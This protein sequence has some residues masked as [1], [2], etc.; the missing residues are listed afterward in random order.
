MDLVKTHI[1][2]AENLIMSK[3]KMGKQ[4]EKIYPFSNENIAA[5]LPHFNLQGKDC[6]T[7]LGSGDQALDFAY[8]GAKTIDTFDINP[9][10][11]YYFYLK[12]AALMSN[13]SYQEYINFFCFKEYLQYLDKNW[14]AFNE[15][16]FNKLVPYLKDDNYIFW[17]TLF[18]TFDFNPV[19][20]RESNGLFT[21][22]EFSHQV[23]SQSIAYLNEKNYYKL[24]EKASSININ[25][26]NSN[27]K[28]LEPKITKKYDFIYLSNIIQYTDTMYEK[29]ILIAV[30]ENRRNGLE[31]YK[32]TIK[33][34]EKN[35]KENGQII[36]G[37][38]YT[39]DIRDGSESIYDGEL[40]KQI[41]NEYTYLY[42][43]SITTIL[44]NAD[45]SHKYRDACLIYTKK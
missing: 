5:C 39:P 33:K 4:F 15:E 23:L 21:S 19:E 18:D 14:N 38:L 29:N 25:F 20:I 42:F 27:I 13:I 26:L 35:L 37:Y 12:K 2:Q 1:A 28:D 36:A 11:K 9:L 8:H 30:S 3:N 17:F 7:V 45:S 6:L 24:K 10:T 40:R 32:N 34:L 16:T 31:S 22:D 43:P 44:M 41:F